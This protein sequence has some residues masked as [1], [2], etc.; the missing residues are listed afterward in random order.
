MCL[1]SLEREACLIMA[2]NTHRQESEYG[3]Y[4]YEL[5]E[6][7]KSKRQDQSSSFF[8]TDLEFER[9]A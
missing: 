6:V 8:N 4:K 9:M 3:I 5:T 1:A 7:S 2:D